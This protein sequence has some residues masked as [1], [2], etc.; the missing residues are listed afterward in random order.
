MVAT[1]GLLQGVVHSAKETGIDAEKAVSE[2]ATGALKAAYAVSEEV[3][4]KV[5]DAATGTIDGV[6]VVLKEPFLKK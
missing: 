5:R 1:K 2:A 3:G 6:K 4:N